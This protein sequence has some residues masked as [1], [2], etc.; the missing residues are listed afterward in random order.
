MSRKKSDIPP[1]DPQIIIDIYVK[2]L[3]SHLNSILSELSQYSERYLWPNFHSKKTNPEHILSILLIINVTKDNNMTALFHLMVYRTTCIALLKRLPYFSEEVQVSMHE[4]GASI[5]FI[6]TCFQSME[7][8]TI[9]EEII[10]ISSISIWYCLSPH[11]L[12]YELNH[13][14]HS[15]KYW[16]HQIKKESKSSQWCA[17]YVDTKNTPKARL[18]A[19]LMDKYSDLILD[20]NTRNFQANLLL[21]FNNYCAKFI[22]L[23]TDIVSQLLTRR[24]VHSLIDDRMIVVKSNIS[25]ICQTNSEKKTFRRLVDLLE[26]H[27]RFDLDNHTDEPSTEFILTG[28]HNRKILRFQRLAFLNVKLKDISLLNHNFLLN[29][30]KLKQCLY[31]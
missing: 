5:E 2:L 26:F 29:K 7:Y 3:H 14:N 6:I 12:R 18:L 24:F 21:L 16:K 19:S 17:F 10:K 11:R 31:F 9:Q 22:T 28:S 15:I 30:D 25:G 20:S 8:L 13:D 27:M 4:V 1:F 23:I